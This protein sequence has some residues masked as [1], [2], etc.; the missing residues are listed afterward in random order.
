MRQ[1]CYLF[2][3][4]QPA[5]SGGRGVEGRSVG[6]VADLPCCLLCLL[7]VVCWRGGGVR[8]LVAREISNRLAG[9]HT[10]LHIPA[11]THPPT[12]Q[13]TP[14]TRMRLPSASNS[15]SSP[16][17]LASR[18][19]SSASLSWTPPP[20][21]PASC[22][23]CCCVVAAAAEVRMVSRRYR[24]RSAAL[25]LPSKK[26]PGDVICG[27]CSCRVWGIGENRAVGWRPVRTRARNRVP[28]ALLQP[29]TS[30]A[31]D[32]L[33]A[34][35]VHRRHGAPT[36]PNTHQ[37]SGCKPIHMTCRLQPWP[38]AIA[39]KQHHVTPPHTCDGAVGKLCFV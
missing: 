1:R 38:Q 5:V 7:L 2:R 9:C 11:P 8:A 20:W 12:H 30:H 26:P 10:L 6:A 34:T 4:S 14:P 25:V 35:A 18:A 17:P 39:N 29:S 23:C 24:W 32:L 13:T 15:S 36:K 21:P 3:C 27:I 28:Q 22:C 37:P 33:S 19:S 16:S 31:G